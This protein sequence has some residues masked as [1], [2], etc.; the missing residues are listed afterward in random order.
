M[1]DAESDTTQKVAPV[2]TASCSQSMGVRFAALTVTS[3]S[4]ILAKLAE[5]EAE[6]RTER[7]GKVDVK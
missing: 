3:K 6:Q 2:G 5:L 7:H 4:V 1:S